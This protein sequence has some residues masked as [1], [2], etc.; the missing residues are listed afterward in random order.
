MNFFVD[1]E[2]VPA[3]EGYLRHFRECRPQLKRRC[4]HKFKRVTDFE[5]ARWSTRIQHNVH[6]ARDHIFGKD[7]P[8]NL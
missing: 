2:V 3:E 8:N 5:M 1:R 4:I 7:T 6:K